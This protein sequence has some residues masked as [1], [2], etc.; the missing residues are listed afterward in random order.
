MLHF[1]LVED[2]PDHAAIVSRTLGKQQPS[3]ELFHV[4]NGAEALAYLRHEEPYASS[5]NPDVILLDLKLPKISG[6]EVLQEIRKD[7]ALADIPVII[8]STSDAES[9]IVRAYKNH[10]N[11]Y[12]VKPLDA[13]CFR[14]M[15]EDLQLYWGRW[16]HTP[17][18]IGR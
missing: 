18:K 4:K 16:N 5:R 6:Q 11:S 9:D 14:Q 7:P 12:L 10:V 13:K 2:D 1:L 8:L 15:V 17:Q 3:H